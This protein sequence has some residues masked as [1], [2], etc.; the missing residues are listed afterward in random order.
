MPVSGERVRDA[1]VA[2]PRVLDVSASATDAGEALARPE[3]RAVIVCDSEGRLVGIVTRK[4]LVRE[5]V[6]AGR[7]PSEVSLGE[8]AEEPHFTLD[9]DTAVEDAFRALEAGDYERVPVIEGGRFV[10][11]LSRSVLQRRLAEDEDP[12]EDE[13]PDLPPAA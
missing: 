8:I 6:A 9:A 11:V 13:P 12:P 10:G 3:V 1:M 5:V 7:H 2:A 4:T